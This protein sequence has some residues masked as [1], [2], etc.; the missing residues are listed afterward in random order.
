MEKQKNVHVVPNG[1]QWSAKSAGSNRAANNY[2][3]QAEA[4]VR[5]R[6][7][8]INNQSE[9]LIHGRDGR[10]REKNSYGNDPQN[11]KG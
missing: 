3:T 7:M 8:A 10:I 6:Q 2:D 11:I 4:I 1:N 9:M 5:A